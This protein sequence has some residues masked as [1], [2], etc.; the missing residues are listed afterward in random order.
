MRRPA[1]SSRDKC[2]FAAA[3]ARSRSATVT[4]T[5][6][7]EA[8]DHLRVT[9]AEHALPLLIVEQYVPRALEIADTVYLMNRGQVAFAG[10]ADGLDS[11]DLTRRYLG[12]GS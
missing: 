4:Q 12:V 8:L 1:R 11:G 2:R 10:P 3:T 6:A 5:L 9:G 7:L